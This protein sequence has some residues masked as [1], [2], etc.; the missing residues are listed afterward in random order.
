MLA[1]F[2]KMR[3]M[4]LVEV[5]IAVVI[6]GILLALGAGSF[7]NW[8]QNAQTRTAAE[9]IQN[10]MQLARSEA[11]RRNTNTMFVMCDALAG[12]T[13]T[14]WDVLAASATATAT[15]CGAPAGGATDWDLVQRRSAQEGSRN[16]VASGVNNSNAIA[17]NSFGRAVTISNMSPTSLPSAPNPLVQGMIQVDIANPK[18]NK[19]MRVMVTPG[20]SVRMCDPDFSGAL[21]NNMPNDPRLC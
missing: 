15:A 1:Q 4:T 17:F 6:F 7:S 3:G 8:I 16:A 19:P 13:G 9:S 18:G 11:V 20:G 2:H 5:M 12:G 14:S 10:G 21:R